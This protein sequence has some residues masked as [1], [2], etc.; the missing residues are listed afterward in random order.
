MQWSCTGVGRIK[1]CGSDGLGKLGNF[2]PQSVK[3]S[4]IFKIRIS[5]D[6]ENEMNQLKVE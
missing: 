3:G 2:E 5:K 1:G 4:A 6:T